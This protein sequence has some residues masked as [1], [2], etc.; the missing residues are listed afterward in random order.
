M[1]TPV[2]NI[3]DREMSLGTPATTVP[4]ADTPPPADNSKTFTLQSNSHELYGRPTAGNNQIP[5]ASAL[6]PGASAPAADAG[7]IPGYAVNWAGEPPSAGGT[8][9]GADVGSIATIIAGQPDATGHPFSDTS[10]GGTVGDSGN[11]GAGPG[12]IPSVTGMPDV[13]NDGDAL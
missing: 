6:G 3:P 9:V 8:Q 5:G 12:P 1:S 10:G 13:D 11:Q 2:N 4:K 7:S